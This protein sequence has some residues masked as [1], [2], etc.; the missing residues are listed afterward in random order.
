[1]RKTQQR[2]S[3][4]VSW[5]REMDNRLELELMGLEFKEEKQRDS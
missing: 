2:Q 1:M 4:T 3:E 5:A